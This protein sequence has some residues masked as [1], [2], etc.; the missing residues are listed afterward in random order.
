MNEPKIFQK[1]PM[2][3]LTKPGTY[4][5]CACG[6]TQTQPFCDGSHKGTSFVPKKVEVTEERSMA[7]CA[8]RHSKNLPL[9]DGT[10]RTL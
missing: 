3:Q 1:S 9:C 8:C 6:A 4:F 2:V 5:Y 7:W 10:H